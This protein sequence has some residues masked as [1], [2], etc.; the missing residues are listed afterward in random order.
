MEYKCRF[1]PA[2][3]STPEALARHYN[4]HGSGKIQET[5]NTAMNLLSKRVA[6]PSLRVQKRIA[7]PENERQV[8]RGRGYAVSNLQPP[9]RFPSLHSHGEIPGASSAFTVL[10]TGLAL[11]QHQTVTL[12]FLAPI[13]ISLLLALQIISRLFRN[14]IW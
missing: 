8:G 4:N 3:F 11:P 9:F 7:G 14:I 10:P 12:L 6:L 13:H 2:T 1:C 5:H